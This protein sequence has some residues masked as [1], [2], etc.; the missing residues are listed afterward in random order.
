MLTV[1]VSHNMYNI[2]LINMF[3]KKFNLKRF[4]SHWQEVERGGEEKKERAFRLVQTVV[5]QMPRARGRQLLQILT[6]RHNL[7]LD[8]RAYLE[9]TETKRCNF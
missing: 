4:V 2:E 1:Q 6:R 9:C 5:Q 8:R 7:T 3:S